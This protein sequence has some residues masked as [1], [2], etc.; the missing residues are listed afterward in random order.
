MRSVR[1]LGLG[2]LLTQLP[3]CLHLPQRGRHHGVGTQIALDGRLD[4]ALQQ[5]GQRLFVRRIGQL[6]QHVAG[7]PLAEW[8]T[9]VGHMRHHQV[10]TLAREELERLHARAARRK[11]Q[12]IQ[13]QRLTRGA[14]S[15]NA[16]AVMTPSVPSEPMSNCLRS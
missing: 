3:H 16:A 10:D 11:Q 13:D 9:H 5:G 15:R 7:V 4:H 12:F 8:R 14:Y 6:D 1:A 2:D